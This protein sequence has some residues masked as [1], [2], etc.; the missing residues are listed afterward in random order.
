MKTRTLIIALTT[1][2]DAE[3]AKRLAHALVS[4]GLAACVNRVAVDSTYRWQGK[5][6]N[7]GEILCV[8][9]STN[10]LLDRLRERVLALHSYDVPE[11]VVLEPAA[12]SAPYLSWALES[13]A[14]PA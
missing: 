7:D 3:S 13:C 4:E 10:D 12:V 11:F 5:I 9:K 8:I 6:E 2:A 14:P 1:V